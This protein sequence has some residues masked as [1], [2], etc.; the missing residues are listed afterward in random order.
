MS[1]GPESLD[2]GSNS[3]WFSDELRVEKQG[4]PPPGQRCSICGSENHRSSD[5]S[6]HEERGAPPAGV[7]CAVCGSENHAAAE[8][9]HRGK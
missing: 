9:P 7:R 2:H 6:Q 4:A 1:E 3:L 5:C 8:C